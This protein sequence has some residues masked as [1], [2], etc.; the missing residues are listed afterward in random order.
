MVRLASNITTRT[1]IPILNQHESHSLP[2]AFSNTDWR[3][4]RT[5]GGRWGRDL[6]PGE[7]SAQLF[8]GG[9]S[10]CQR[11]ARRSRSA[12]PACFAQR[13]WLIPNCRA[14]PNIDAAYS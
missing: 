13:Q 6:S 12:A 3:R 9:D 8:G 1:M 2:G 5:A 10:A 11:M 4:L 14:R 7:P